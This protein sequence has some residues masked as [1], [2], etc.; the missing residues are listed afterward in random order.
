MLKIAAG[1]GIGVLPVISHHPIAP[2]TPNRPR[3]AVHVLI[4]A[5][6]QR[7]DGQPSGI[8]IDRYGYFGDDLHLRIGRR[9]GRAVAASEQQ[10]G[11]YQRTPLSYRRTPSK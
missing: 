5:V 3:D 4:G 11:E 7:A 10:E 6:N 9:I 2:H 8:D 1:V